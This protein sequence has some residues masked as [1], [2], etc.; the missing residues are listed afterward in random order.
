[1]VPS[2]GDVYGFHEGFA[3]V[4]ALMQHFTYPDVVAAAIRKSAAALETSE[5]LTDIARQFGHT[6]GS[7]G[8]LRTVRRTTDVATPAK[9]DPNAES[10]DI[11]SVFASAV[12][13]AFSTVYRRRAAATLRIAGV[14][15]TPR[16]DEL[17]AELQ[18]ELARRAASVAKQF[19]TIVIRAVDLCPPV[20]LELGE[21]LRAVIT[22]DHELF[23]DDA[24]CY[25][26]AWIDAF[27]K[28][29][30]YPSNVTSLS[31]DALLWR[32][33]DGWEMKIDALRFGMLDF[34]SAPG[35]PDT[36]DEV[37]RRARGLAEFIRASG[38]LVDFGLT[39]PDKQPG[40]QPPK[41]VS[42]RS[43]RR[44]GQDG[45]VAFDVIAQVIQK[46]MVTVKGR[47]LPF[48][49]GSTIVIGP[50]GDVR[51]VIS[52][53]LDS[54]RRLDRM[55]SFAATP[56][57]DQLWSSYITNATPPFKLLHNR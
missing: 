11:G 1:M 31:E 6:T 45:Q 36:D 4:V 25:R 38:R 44:I 42:L 20:D 51:Y 17:S 18:Q 24:W 32:P 30:I 28:R 3:D 56:T 35:E 50:G 26:E 27:R 5:L 16:V 52:K 57:G 46:R 55:L 12:F 14:G 33:P 47:E 43:S 53:S 34:Q 21:F 39:R 13:E 23:P 49:G 22:A 29:E 10:H 9:Y 37:R 2:N 40:I 48:Y 15:P 54:Q 7:Q 41:V 8:P 19:L